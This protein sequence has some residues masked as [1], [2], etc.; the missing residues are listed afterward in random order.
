[1]STAENGKVGA[2]V[3]WRI[4]CLHRELNRKREGIVTNR[5]SGASCF[6]FRI[7]TAGR[8]S[9]AGVD[10]VIPVSIG[11]QTNLLHDLNPGN[12]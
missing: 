4:I 12:P 2:V 1:M 7:Y 11:D 5:G 9:D 3:I 6:S 10:P 8:Y